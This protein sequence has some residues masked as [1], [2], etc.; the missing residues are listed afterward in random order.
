MVM[1]QGL[2]PLHKE[3]Y[4]LVHSASE[5]RGVAGQLTEQ[6]KHLGLMIFHVQLIRLE[7]HSSG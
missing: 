7:C 5:G 4:L 1:A 6:G 3:G 2:D